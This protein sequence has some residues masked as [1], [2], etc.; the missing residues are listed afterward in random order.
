MKTLFASKL[1]LSLRKKILNLYIW[2]SVLHVIETYIL[3]PLDQKYFG[4]V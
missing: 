2:S 1:V 4:R 3:F